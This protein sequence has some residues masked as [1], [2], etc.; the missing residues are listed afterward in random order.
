MKK[1]HTQ[2]HIQLKRLKTA[3]YIAG[4]NAIRAGTRFSDF[5]GM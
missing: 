1:N 4:I 2:L 3:L 5:G